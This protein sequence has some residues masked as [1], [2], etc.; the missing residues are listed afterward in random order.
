MNQK[1]LIVDDNEKNRKLLRVILQSTGYETIESENGEDGVRMAKENLPAFIL[2]DIQMPVMGGTEALKQIRSDETTAKIP[3]IAL[4]SYAMTG[5]RD[6]FL[7]EGFDG[8]ISK[9]LKTSELMDIIKKYLK[10]SE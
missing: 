2:M 8:Y 9:P 6:K 1:I 10:E 4:T 5:D 7:A 3:V